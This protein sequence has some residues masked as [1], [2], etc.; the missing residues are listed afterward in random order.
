MLE[1]SNF[2]GQVVPFGH[3][4]GDGAR[5]LSFRTDVTYFRN[6]ESVWYS[7]PA[8]P[9]GFV[10]VVPLPL[11][12]ALLPLDQVAELQDISRRFSVEGRVC[13]TDGIRIEAEKVF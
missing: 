8:Q 3:L 9:T 13:G 6:T 2:F 12:F 11:V 4:G 5:G 10:V 7:S 1:V